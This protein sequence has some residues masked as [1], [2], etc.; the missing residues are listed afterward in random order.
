MGVNKRTALQIVTYPFKNTTK[1]HP[2]MSDQNRT[3]NDAPTIMARI[4]AAAE[5]L[6]TPCPTCKVEK[7]VIA[8]DG[9]L[10]RAISVQHERSC[11]EYIP[12]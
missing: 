7:S 10:P 4:N 5:L 8:I 12:G 6:L 11:P 2:T 1:E 9:E 3:E